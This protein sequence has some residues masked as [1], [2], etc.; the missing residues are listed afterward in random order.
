MTPHWT[1]LDWAAVSQMPVTAINGAA[2]RPYDEFR[3]G[4]V[5]LLPDAPL[6]G[7]V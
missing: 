5:T 7:L 3:A 2:A 1:A 4:S 6:A